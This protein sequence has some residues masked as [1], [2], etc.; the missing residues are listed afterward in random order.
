MDLSEKILN[1]PKRKIKLCTLNPHI[2]C[3]LCAG[4]LV[5]ATTILECLHTF[6]KSCIVRYLQSSKLCPTCGTLVHE[7]DPL[8]YI[9]LDRTMQDIMNKILPDI[10][11]KEKQNEEEFLESIRKKEMQTQE[12]KP[13]VSSKTDLVESPNYHKNSEHFNLCLELDRSGELWLDEM[14]VVEIRNKNIRCPGRV[15][16]LH[17]KKLV[18]KFY[19][20]YCSRYKLIFKCNDKELDDEEHVKLIYIVHWKRKTQPI[21]LY[22]GFKKC[23]NED[24]MII[25]SS[26]SKIDYTEGSS[27]SKKIVP[28]QRSSSNCVI[29]SNESSSSNHI[30]NSTTTL[31]D[32][33]L[34]D[35]REQ[36]DV[37]KPLAGDSISDGFIETINNSVSSDD[38]MLMDTAYQNHDTSDSVT[39][40]GVLNRPDCDS[41]QYRRWS[42]NHQNG[43][44]SNDLKNEHG[45]SESCFSHL[46]NDHH[47]SSVTDCI[48]NGSEHGALQ[49]KTVIDD[50]IVSDNLSTNSNISTL[51]DNSLNLNKKSN[52]GS[53]SIKLG[54]SSKVPAKSVDFKSFNGG[55]V[56]NSLLY[57][58]N[59]ACLT[60]T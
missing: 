57:A 9:K 42:E 14:E 16:I 38:D 31:I 8:S 20:P 7:T 17:L 24:H 25:D 18:S 3:L 4:Y 30:E 10:S 43:H 2:V 44:D 47:N 21:I 6:C 36:N 33:S 29:D 53:D 56:N 28:W 37:G 52:I 35:F 15:K 41:N 22:Y 13:N 60:V 45:A 49:N 26:I 59:H 23:N 1:L 19:E 32:K 40:T 5:D 48:Q 27:S 54:S 55:I 12:N 58:S 39:I 50:T 51:K 34:T 46:L 11:A